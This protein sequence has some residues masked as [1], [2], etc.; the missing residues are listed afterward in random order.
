[1]KV[2]ITI[3]M[4]LWHSFILAQTNK[5][6]ILLLGSDHLNQIYKKENP[7]TD[8]FNPERQ[9]QITEFALFLKAYHPD[10]IMVEVLPE[11]QNE[12]DSLYALYLQDKLEIDKI[13][14]GRSEVYQ[15][16]FRLGKQLNINRIYC[17]DAPGGTSQSILD[18]GNNIELYKKETADLRKIVGEKYTA[19][20]K[21]N[22]SI[23]DYLI[24]LN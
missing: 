1:M 23:K 10:M 15:L 12:V 3:M 5:I 20:Q 11:N 9:K 22:L 18:N 4:V 19:L 7:Y 2:K 16:G 21:G 13:E 17:V 6:E 24:F 8:V 14:E